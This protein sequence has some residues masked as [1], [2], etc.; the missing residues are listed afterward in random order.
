MKMLSVFSYQLSAIFLILCLFAFGVQAAPVGSPASLLQKGQ[1]DFAL[2]GGYLSERAMEGDDDS[3]YDVNIVHGYHS[4]SYG[5]TDR[6][7]IKAKAGG[8]Y[9]HLNEETP[10]GIQTETSLSG[11]FGLGIQL[12]GIIFENQDRGFEWDGS[13]QFVYM[14]SH[15]KRSGKANTDWYEWQ[16]STCVAKALG[17]FKPYAGVKFSTVDL[18]HDDG[19]GNTNSYDEDESVGP[20]IGTDIYLGRDQDIVINLEIGFLLGNE[21]YGGIKY[22]F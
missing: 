8:I 7:T 20:F 19:K 18:D 4:R 17:K 3:S 16:V 14:R 6:L 13:G 22:R 12:K 2:E 5:L 15:R 10:A 1:W 9:A 11:G 21:Y